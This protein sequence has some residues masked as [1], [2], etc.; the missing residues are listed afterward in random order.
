LKEYLIVHLTR[1]Q[2]R[3]VPLAVTMDAVLQVK[4]AHPGQ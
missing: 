1:R 2:G 3:R 4:D